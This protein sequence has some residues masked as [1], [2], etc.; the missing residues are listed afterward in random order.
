MTTQ[1]QRFERNAPELF[2]IYKTLSEFHEGMTI[3]CPF[4][5]LEGSTIEENDCP[6]CGSDRVAWSGSGYDCLECGIFFAD[7]A[8]D[9]PRRRLTDDDLEELQP[10][11][12]TSHGNPTQGTTRQPPP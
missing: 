7:Y 2:A 1:F 6:G 10:L 8:A 11:K 12:G 5:N 9:P 4:K 3:R